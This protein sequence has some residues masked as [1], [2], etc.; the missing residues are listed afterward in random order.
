MMGGLLLCLAGKAQTDSTKTKSDTMR[1]GSIIIINDG[2]EEKE[3]KTETTIETTTR[4]SSPPRK[5][6]KVST[7]WMIFDIGFANYNDRTNYSSPEAQ[8]FVHGQLPGEPAAKSDFALKPSSFNLNVWLF[9]QRM[10]LYKNYVNVKYGIGIDLNRYY[11]KSDIR[12][13]DGPSPYVERQNV[14]LKYN[15]FGADYVTVPLMLNINPTP[16]RR[17]SSLSFSVGASASYL[18]SARNRQKSDAFGKHKTSSDFNL[19]R[20]KFSYIGELGLGPV[21][22]YGS[23][24]I[25]PLHQ[26]GVELHPYTI[27]VRFSSF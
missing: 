9:M 25:T 18:Y 13:I 1:V 23:Y 12:Y 27:G 20:W 16:S 2:K 10:S 4:H 24:A 11:H 14:E 15:R 6:K 26:Y 22:L 8:S 19:E 3:I 17:G 7:N 5:R 21:K